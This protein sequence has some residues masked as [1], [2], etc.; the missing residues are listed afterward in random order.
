MKSRLLIFAACA[1][2]ALLWSTGLNAPFVY[3]DKIEV[4]GNPTLRIFSA[5]SAILLY[6]VSRPVLIATY[7][8]NWT[9][10]GLN[11]IGY[12]VLSIAIH[13]VN[14]VLVGLLL[15]RLSTR[16]GARTGA[17]NGSPWPPALGWMIAV[18]WG[19]HP[20]AVQGVTYITGR[21]DALCA[22]FWLAASVAWLN[23]RQR[24]TL[25][26]MAAA[27]CTKELAVTLP[28]WLCVL[29][30]PTGRE[31]R[32]IGIAAGMIA[33]GAALRVGVMGWP[34]LPPQRSLPVQWAA[35]G[36]VTARYLGL[37]L[38]PYG[39]S[40]LHDPVIDGPRL[41]VSGALSGVAAVLSGLSLRSV[42]RAWRS[43]SETPAFALGWLILV[44]WLAP[45]G[46]LPLKE[47]MAE[48]RA[49]LV[50]V[51]VLAALVLGLV[52][53]RMLV[54]GVV[55]L[56]AMNSTVTVLQNY[57]WNNE[58]RLWSAA[59]QTYP[60]SA[61]T[62]FGMAD[63]LRFSQQWTEAE[64]QYRTV[65]AMDP[66]HEDAAINL[67]IVLAEQGRTEEA[68]AQWDAVVLANR[69]SCSA[70]NNLGALAARSGDRLQAMNEYNSALH[71][72]PGDPVALVNLGDL[73]WERGD[74]QSA[75]SY[76]ARYLTVLP[77]GAEAERVRLRIG[78]TE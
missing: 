66:T 18:L 62:R 12:H 53:A 65:I 23:G 50:G 71:W 19:A 11:P 74:T 70:H 28:I 69:E 67:G 5:Y 42:W 68:R 4:V 56:L 63:A 61:L 39:Q 35:Q 76:Y 48:H 73:F 75:R 3:D 8:A 36:E 30:R 78:P 13:C 29:R 20:M 15:N 58:V 24:Q 32:T 9:L 49:Y 57:L 47:L 17:R 37:W 54:P 21:S 22:T 77:H 38:L 10:G 1:G 52:R 33:V 31:W 16:I 7:A 51:P 55:G 34:S 45:S 43:N 59:A 25:L 27:L 40:V 64:A 14:V 41:L 2:L 46:A 26:W 72:C 6:N 44:C 60:A